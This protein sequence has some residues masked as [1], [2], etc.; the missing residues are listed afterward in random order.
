MADDYPCKLADC[1]V[2]DKRALQ[3]YRAKRATWLSW[4]NTG[5]HAQTLEIFDP[6]GLSDMLAKTPHLSVSLSRS[7]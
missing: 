1:D 7:R 3:S 6:V 2:D 5:F 4:I